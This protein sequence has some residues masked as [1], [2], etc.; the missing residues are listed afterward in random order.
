MKVVEKT[1]RTVDEAVE[2]CLLELGAEKDQV[3]IEILEEPG[4]K[5][6]FGL[7]GQ[8]PARVRVI[9]NADPSSIAC[10]FL[11]E[12]IAAMNV[13]AD[14]E[15]F[16][17]DDHIL[18]NIT[19]SDLGILIGRRGDTL[20]AI[21]FLTGLAVARKAVDKTRIVIDIEGYRKR[22]EETLIKLAK[23]LAEK[24]KRTGTRIVLEPM[25]PQE[26]RIIHTA[27]QGEYK[28]LTFSEG[29]EPNRRVVISL[30]RS[31]KDVS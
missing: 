14:F 27:L 12:L 20:E 13:N 26:R 7:F 29:E 5:G 25:S 28:I 8:K 9:Y 23:R 11:R 10:K 17:R 24:V 30:K 18:I 16:H 1:G 15:V 21:Q 6:L 31:S 22:R 2:S 4:R 3:S 19:G